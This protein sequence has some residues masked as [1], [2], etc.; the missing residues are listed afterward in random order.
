MLLLRDDLRILE[1]SLGAPKCWD[2][3]FWHGDDMGFQHGIGDLVARQ[4]IRHG[5]ANEFG[6]A[7]HTL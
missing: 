3:H 7:Q 6:D 4:Q 1:S 2:L 5:M